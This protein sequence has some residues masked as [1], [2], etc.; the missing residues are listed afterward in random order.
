MSA[1][2]SIVLQEIQVFSRLGLYDHERRLGQTLI[3]DLELKLDL[4]LAGKSTKVADTIDYAAVSVLVREL[5]QS[6][7]FILIE[8]LAHE[9]ITMLFAKFEKLEG[10]K[11]EVHKTIINAQEFSGK[12][13]VKLYRTRV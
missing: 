6:R 4:S 11:I 10:I 7:E 12:A 9:I 5:G 3:V 13:S 1:A 2:D 8:E